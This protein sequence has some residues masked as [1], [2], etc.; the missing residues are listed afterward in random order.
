[1]ADPVLFDALIEEVELV[2][3]E[4]YTEIIPNKLFTGTK[5]L[6]PFYNYAITGIL[7]Y[8]SNASIECAKIKSNI[9]IL[10]IDLP[11]LTYLDGFANLEKLILIDS[12]ESLINLDEISNLSNLKS[13][14][15]DN[16]PAITSIDGLAALSINEFDFGKSNKINSFQGLK[17]KKDSTNRENIVLS[18]F[19]ELLSLDGIEF[20][21]ATKSITLYSCSSLKNAAALDNLTVLKKIE[22]NQN[23]SSINLYKLD[24]AKGIISK[25][26]EAISISIN[27]FTE[28]SEGDFPEMKYLSISCSGMANL[29]WLNKF[30]NL[31]GLKINCDDL[32][33]IS[34]ISYCKNLLGFIVASGSIKDLN[35]L[36]QA[37]QLIALNFNGCNTLNSIN[38]IKDLINLK[39]CGNDF[40]NIE[41]G[42]Y[43]YGKPQQNLQLLSTGVECVSDII[44]FSD[45]SA[46][47]DIAN[48]FQLKYFTNKITKINF[49][50]V[51][52]QA[53]DSLKNF[54]GLTSFSSTKSFVNDN[55]IDELVELPN[56]Q[57]L[58]IVEPQ[59]FILNKVVKINF[60]IKLYDSTSGVELKNV[61][62]KSLSI[63]NT[64][65]NDLPCLNSV[66]INDLK[67]VK[68]KNIS[69]L[70]NNNL[71]L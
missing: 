45:L 61:Q 48:L 19:D 57:V 60:D 50:N 9:K 27:K 47:K 43:V 64:K 18:N 29:N 59:E 11:K 12:S 34:G 40:A 31:I 2:S 51:G 58:E 6:Q 69:S 36:S 1:M 35:A 16:C 41:H 7:K 65:F 30:P 24:S 70:K 52:V 68:S 66:T 71:Q 53:F 42:Y 38:F 15:L 3:L 55:L 14:K 26:A 21:H 67:V 63:I 17:G 39:I 56:L 44:S 8:A 49:Y 25:N 28:F 5:K 32:I 10:K 13:L 33:D 54:T 46:L 62:L 37:S 23:S 20:Y 22:Q 4:Y